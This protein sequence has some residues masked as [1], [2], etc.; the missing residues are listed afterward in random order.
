[1][2]ADEVSDHQRRRLFKRLDDLLVLR[3][4]PFAIHD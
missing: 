4:G 2:V 3:V 1:L